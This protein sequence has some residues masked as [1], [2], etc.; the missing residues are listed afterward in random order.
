MPRLIV[1]Q[2]LINF[3]EGS[4]VITVPPYIRSV[5]DRAFFENGSVEIMKLP[6]GLTDIGDEAFR[7]CFRMREIEMPSRV[8]TFGRGVFRDCHA[9]ESLTLPE[10]V[11]TV[12]REML[13]GCHSLRVL[14]LP[15][16]VKTVE[17]DAL[18]D[19]ESVEVLSAAPELYA[20]FPEELLPVAWI[21]YMEE[22]AE[23]GEDE[24]TERTAGEDLASL[25]EEI[26]RRRR[27]GAMKYLLRR[28]L[29]EGEDLAP[30][31]ERA[32]AEGS[33]DIAAML[34]EEQERRR[35]EGR[36]SEEAFDWDPFA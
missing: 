6:P 22:H 33:S 31:I 19:L 18:A 36:L 20:E 15:S 7:F 30:W 5:A 32:A 24:E 17:K 16:T 8:R 2:T 21:T 4:A 28:N 11:K 34:L 10:G 9:L 14:R 35:Q 27:I 26:I 29:L 13:A 3:D 23:N 1:G 12:D 25:T